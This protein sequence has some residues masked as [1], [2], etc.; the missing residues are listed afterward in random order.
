MDDWSFRVLAR[1]LQDL[2]GNT[3]SRKYRHVAVQ[4]DPERSGFADVN[5]ARRF[6]QEFLAQ[7]GVY[8]YWGAAEE[9]LRKLDEMS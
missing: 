7:D 9:F 5:R 3:L 2:P 1:S 4:I 8:I 6:L